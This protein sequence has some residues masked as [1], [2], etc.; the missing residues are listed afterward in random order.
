[1]VKRI[2]FPSMGWSRIAFRA[3]FEKLPGVEVVSPPIVTREIVKIGAKVSP[4][5]VCLPFKV[6]LGEFIN[7]IENHDVHTF[8]MS[9]DCGPCRLGFYAPIQDKILKDLGYDAEVLPIQQDDLLN[10]KWADTLLQLSNVSN[11]IMKYV[12]VIQSTRIALIK[13]SYIA[14]ITKLEGLIR[15]REIKLGDTT[16]TVDHLMNLLDNEWD[17]YNLHN[18]DKVVKREFSKIPIKRNIQPLRIIVTGENHIVMEPFINMDVVKKFGE[19]G[20]EVH[21]VNTLY[22]WILHKLH[23]NF[24]RKK[25]EKLAKPYIPLDI[26]GEA[27]WVIGHYIEAQ[28][29]G[30]DGFIHLYP[31]TCMPENTAR[32]I[33]EG[34]SPDPFYMPVQFYSLDEH[35]GYEGMR[36][37]LEAFIDLMRANHE[38]NPKF[39]NNY[40]E[41]PEIKAIFDDKTQEDGISRFINHIF[42]PLAN[43]IGIIIKNLFS[44]EESKPNTM[45]N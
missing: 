38:N 45:E 23:I 25:L 3:L 26:G 4:E 44:Q 20:V 11:P 15:C 39:M 37:R 2:S 18:F 7:M 41:P 14:D 21:L 27:M 29:H 19:E 16:R 36:T 6:T 5:F 9:I 13:M 43:N 31:F 17:V 8:I 28:S 10:F 42:T 34:Q 40:V 22:D 32:G 12:D 1:M 30:F 35:T 33:L 24:K